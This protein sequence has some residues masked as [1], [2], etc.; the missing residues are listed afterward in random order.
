MSPFVTGMRA[1]A[2]AALVGGYAWM[3]P[4]TAA[5][6]P[7]TTAL[8]GMLSQGYTTSNCKPDTGSGGLAALK[9]GQNSMP[10]GPVSAEYIL[11][12]NSKDTTAG[13]QGGTSSMT[14]SPCQSGDPAPDTWSSDNSNNTTA[15]QIAC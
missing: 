5:P 1:V 3:A 14:L 6:D 2:T 8:A 7:N 15:G 4:A 13:F 12:G 11:Y 9:C 10:N